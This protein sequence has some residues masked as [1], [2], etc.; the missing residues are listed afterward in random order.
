ME[1]PKPKL[2]DQMVISRSKF[3]TLF[4]SLQKA[5][6]SIIG[7]TVSNEAIVYQELSSCE[8]LPQGW[9][10]RREPGTYR[11]EKRDD[12]ALFGFNVGPHSPKKYLFPPEHVFWTAQRKESGYEVYEDKSELPRYAFVGLRACE[13][14]AV[15]LQDKVFT[16]GEHVD[17]HYQKLRDASLIV[18]ANCTQ[19]DGTCFCV[20]MGTGPKAEKGFDLALTEVLDGEQHYFVVEVGSK[21]G[22][23]VLEGVSFRRAK[24]KELKLAVEAR[25]RAAGQMGRTLETDGLKDI[26]QSNPDSVHWD[27]V[28]KRCLSCGNCTMVCPTCFCTTVVDR[29]DLKG[30][31]CERIRRW[32][33]CFTNEFSYINGGSVRQ[34]T[35]SRYRQWMMHKLANWIDQFGTMGCVGCGRCITWC[36]V[37]IDITQEAA[38]IREREGDQA[39]IGKVK[40]DE[41]AVT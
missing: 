20:S 1:K 10:D 28:A 39:S 8:E 31:S 33:S 41:H 37:G 40:E 29:T 23:A 18:A 21:R 13:V 22:A 35:K 14:N 38:A 34:S 5:G 26:L 27:K 17:Q 3:G 11:L 7:P 25:D 24:P 30:T 12:Q 6:Y 9:T 19:A 15:L 16:S 4:T 2:G 32:D 36:P